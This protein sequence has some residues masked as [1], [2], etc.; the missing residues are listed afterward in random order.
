MKHSQHCNIFYSI[1]FYTLFQIYPKKTH[2]LSSSLYYYIYLWLPEI[3]L[4]IG[5]SKTVSLG[6][7]MGE[8]WGKGED[9]S[10]SGGLG[11]MGR[12]QKFAT[13]GPKIVVKC[14]RDVDSRVDLAVVVILSQK[15]PRKS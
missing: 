6:V 10:W 3:I 14:G 4:C 12:I 1:L 9:W 11:G 15:T 5:Q 2:T 8:F 13:L 7:V